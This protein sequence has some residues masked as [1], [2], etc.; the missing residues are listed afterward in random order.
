M[1]RKIRE[2]G[3]FDKIFNLHILLTNLLRSTGQEVLSAQH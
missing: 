1:H 3:I 2:M